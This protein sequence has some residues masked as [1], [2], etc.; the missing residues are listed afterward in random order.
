MFASQKLSFGTLK[1]L[2]RMSLRYIISERLAIL[3]N[4]LYLKILKIIFKINYILRL[5]QKIQIRYTAARLPNL[6]LYG[7]RQ[8]HV[9]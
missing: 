9:F 8:M 2:K 3:K 7:H 6:F 5:I 4:C 1:G